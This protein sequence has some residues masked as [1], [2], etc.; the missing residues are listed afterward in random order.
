M[1]FRIVQPRN[2]PGAGLLPRDWS[3]LPTAPLGDAR[4]LHWKA[5][6][7]GSPTTAARGSPGTTTDPGTW[8]RGARA[9]RPVSPP[10]PPFNPH[11]AAPAPRFC[12]TDL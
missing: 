5:S 10:S 9:A 8:Y 12:P 1:I 2:P 4:R 3:G 6:P 11:T 7:A